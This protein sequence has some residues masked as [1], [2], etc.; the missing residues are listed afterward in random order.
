[1]SDGGSVGQEC[2]S[3]LVLLIGGLDIASEMEG[4]GKVEICLG[5]LGGF[6]YCLLEGRCSILILALVEIDGAQLSV[7]PAAVGVLQD[8]V[9][10]GLNRLLEPICFGIGVCKGELGK[11]VFWR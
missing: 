7:D 2:E 4:L 10:A 6:F 1:M 9:L 5:V 3:F 8:C 11:E